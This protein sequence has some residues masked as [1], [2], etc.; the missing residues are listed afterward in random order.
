MAR[1]VDEKNKEAENVNPTR[2]GIRSGNPQ[3]DPDRA[4]RDPPG[5]EKDQRP[6]SPPSHDN[7][8]KGVN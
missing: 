6:H 2:S 8:R 1:S 5:T 4:Q 7:G 3:L